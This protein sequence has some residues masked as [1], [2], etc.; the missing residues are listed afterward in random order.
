MASNKFSL[1]SVNWL[2]IVL[3]ILGFWLSA[4]L[5]LDAVVMPS[6]A[7]SGMMD[8]TEVATVGYRLFGT[9][10]HLELV[11]AAAVLSGVLAARFRSDRASIRIHWHLLALAGG[12]ILLATT[13]T[14]VLTPAMGGLG[15]S[16]EW[17]EASSAI[18]PMAIMH[19]AYWSLEA[20]KFVLGLVLLARCYQQAT[21]PNEAF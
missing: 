6:L 2:P 14:Y 11:C 8:R 13:S 4:S 3:G 15:A 20:C 17:F 21:Q 10:N 12:L 16:L 19:A 9:F 18:A 5:T 7:G 1:S